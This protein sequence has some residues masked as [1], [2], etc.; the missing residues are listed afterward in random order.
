[1]RFLSGSY[2]GFAAGLA[3]VEFSNFGAVFVAAVVVG[4]LALAALFA[5]STQ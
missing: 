3:T 5:L 4:C 1:M 2:A